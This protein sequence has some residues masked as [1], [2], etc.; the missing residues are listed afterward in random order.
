MG[1]HHHRVAACLHTDGS[2]YLVEGVIHIG[3]FAGV[4]HEGQSRY[5]AGVRTA[6]L[7]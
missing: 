6:A 4:R 2:L 7:G 1:E 3:C 5:F